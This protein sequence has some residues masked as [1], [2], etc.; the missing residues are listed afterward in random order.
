MFTTWSDPA[1]LNPNDA[2]G[3]GQTLDLYTDGG[4]RARSRRAR[5]AYDHEHA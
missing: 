2:L 1:I 5:S 4:Y 3:G